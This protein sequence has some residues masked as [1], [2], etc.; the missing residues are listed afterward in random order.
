MKLKK[1][2]TELQSALSEVGDVEV[3]ISIAK[4]PEKPKDQQH[5]L[6]HSGFV[7]IEDRE[8]EGKSVCIRDW[9]Y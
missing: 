4:Q 2:I 5:L 3:E 6:S 8:E 9:P 1:L 7:A